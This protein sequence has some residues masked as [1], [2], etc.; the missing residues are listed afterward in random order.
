MRAGRGGRPATASVTRNGSD[1]GGNR[2]DTHYTHTDVYT[3]SR[4][5]VQMHVP[6]LIFRLL[7]SLSLGHYPSLALSLSILT[8][9]SSPRG[10]SNHISLYVIL[11]S[12]AVSPFL[13]FLFFSPRRTSPVSLAYTPLSVTMLPRRVRTAS[14]PTVFDLS[15]SLFLFLCSFARRDVL[16]GVCS[17]LCASRIRLYLCL[18]LS[19]DSRRERAPNS[20]RPVRRTDAPLPPL[21]VEAAAAAGHFA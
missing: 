11:L 6:S 7:L 16:C 4:V 14:S 5:H 15:L 10:L 20:I 17:P 1:V 13:P 2:G 9:L 8:I 21:S 3:Q 18:F 12:G 19:L